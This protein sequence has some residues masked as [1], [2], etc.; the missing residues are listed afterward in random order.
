MLGPV[1]YQYPGSAVPIHTAKNKDISQK[2]AGNGKREQ[3][4]ICTVR[5]EEEGASVDSAFILVAINLPLHIIREE[6]CGMYCLFPERFASFL[7]SH[8]V[9]F[10]FYIPFK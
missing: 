8:I 5:K 2:Y 1:I 10:L 3:Q 6:R 7:S 9:S 4:R